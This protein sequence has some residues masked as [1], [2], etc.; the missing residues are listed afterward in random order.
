MNNNSKTALLLSNYAQRMER[1][2]YAFEKHNICLL[3]SHFDKYDEKTLPV[4]P[5][6]IIVVDLTETKA[7]TVEH[8]NIVKLIRAQYPMH[9]IP[10]LALLKSVIDEMSEQFDSILLQ[11]IHADQIAMR[12]NSLIRL[13]QMQREITL[14]LHTLSQNFNEVPPLPQLGD[15]HRFSILFIGK[16]TPKFMVIINALQDKNVSVVAAFTSFTAFDYLYEK[17]FDAV[18]M[19]GLGTIELAYSITETMRKNAKL[20]HVP[21]LLLVDKKT[22]DDCDTV[23]KVGMNDIIDTSVSLDEISARILEQA[24]FHRTHKHLKHRFQ[25]LGSVT[26]IDQETGLFNQHFFNAHMRRVSD[27]YSKLG[28]PVTLALIRFTSKTPQDK[29]TES[30]FKQIGSM[31]RNL[32]RMEDTPARLDANIFAIAFMGHTV[33]QLKP[34]HERLSSIL[35]C[36]IIA[37]PET[38]A[39]MQMNMEITFNALTEQIQRSNVA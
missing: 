1:Y 6:N 14:R 7:Y 28:K 39:P 13:S 38:G 20:Y 4:E 31:I 9:T 15:K 11:P 26:V 3:H 16:A 29:L 25:T 35:K 18:V 33:A 27:V 19:N 32:V 23:Y 5:P 21:A 17:N 10:V 34:V 22:F 2:F 8:E 30:A 37:H 24:N 12:A 36:A